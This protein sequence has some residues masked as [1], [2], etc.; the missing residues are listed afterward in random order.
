MERVKEE[1]ENNEGTKVYI[2]RFFAK[3]EQCVLYNESGLLTPVVEHIEYDEEEE[4][5]FIRDEY[6]EI[7]SDGTKGINKAHVYFYCDFNGNP[8]GLAYTD[9]IDGLTTP[10]LKCDDNPHHDRWFIEYGVFK[11]ELGISLWQTTSKRINHYGECA[12][13]MLSVYKK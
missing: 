6:T 13:K 2:D 1:Y 3:K 11:R 12:K 4:L 8:V 10:V 9:A 7:Y 5:F